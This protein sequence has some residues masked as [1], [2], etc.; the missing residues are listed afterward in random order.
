MTS[1]IRVVFRTYSVFGFVACLIYYVSSFFMIDGVLDLQWA[2][3]LFVSGFIPPFLVYLV[4]SVTQK[5]MGGQAKWERKMPRWFTLCKRTI[6]FFWVMQFGLSMLNNG[7]GMTQVMDDNYVLAARGHILKVLTRDEFITLRRQ[8]LRFYII[9]S[10]Y[11]Y[12]MLVGY[13]WYPRKQKMM[14]D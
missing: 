7:W 10:F 9:G 11:L 1:T 8:E 14:E 4:E 13:C 3:L 12:F 5:D 2:V 6:V